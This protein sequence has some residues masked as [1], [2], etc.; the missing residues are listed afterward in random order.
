MNSI[1]AAL[2][3]HKLGSKTRL[4]LKLIALVKSSTRMHHEQGSQ[5]IKMR[6]V[7]CT[8]SAAVKRSHGHIIYIYIYI[9]LLASKSSSAPTIELSLKSCK[10][11]LL[12]PI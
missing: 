8:S 4:Q 9:Y 3:F 2:D 12:T 1:G 6:S 11:Y 10:Y 7:F 5:L